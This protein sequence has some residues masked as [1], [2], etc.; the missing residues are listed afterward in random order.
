MPVTV[1]V[2]GYGGPLRAIE[3]WRMAVAVSTLAAHAGGRLVVSGHGGEAERLAALA[4]DG[5]EVLLESTARSTR[6]NVERSLPLL[7][8]ADRWAIAS[9]R[10]QRRRIAGYLRELRP[11]LLTRLVDPAYG[12]RDGWWMDAGGAP[13]EA[14][15]PLRRA[16][17][18]LRNRGRD[19][20]R[21]KVD[22]GPSSSAS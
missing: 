4:P 8:G 9:D 22:R 1:L 17:W 21:P 19:G 16:A 14:V 15:L 12:W 6:E 7:A 18:R 11:E 5:V 13:Y 10:W 2:P 3:R 20:A